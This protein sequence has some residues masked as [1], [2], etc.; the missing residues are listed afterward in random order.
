[1]SYFGGALK[2][3]DLVIILGMG[4]SLAKVITASG[5]GDVLSNTLMSF[6]MPILVL[7]FILSAILRVALSS[8]TTAMLTT[9]SI[10]APIAAASGAS[11]V[12][13]GLTICAATVGMLIHTDT[14]FWMASGRFDIDPKQVL[15][16]VSLPCTLASIVVFLCILLLNA[17]SSVLPGLY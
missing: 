4:G 1:M 7:A 14:A 3:C 8:G 10:F 13:V 11:P 6:N 12:L 17:F 9:V 15:R 5:I 2:E 16:S